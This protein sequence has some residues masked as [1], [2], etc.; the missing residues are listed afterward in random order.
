MTEEQG[1]L[2]TNEQNQTIQDNSP[3]TLETRTGQE[4]TNICSKEDNKTISSTNKKVKK[5]K[6]PSQLNLE[7]RN[8]T[9]D[10]YNRYRSTSRTENNL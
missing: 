9:N 5:K 1:T 10:F 8:T 6:K 4:T 7:S 2:E 3:K